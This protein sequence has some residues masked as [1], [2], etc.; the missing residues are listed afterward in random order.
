MGDGW[1]H[2]SMHD[3]FCIYPWIHAHFKTDGELKLCCVSGQEGLRDE[4]GVPL[5]LQHHSLREI[6]NS[7]AL[8]TVRRK[9]MEGRRVEACSGCYHEES[10]GKSSHR[11]WANEHWLS[12][13][14]S[15]EYVGRVERSFQADME[16]DDNP[17]YYD[18]RPG[19]QCNLACRMC[20]PASSSLIARDEVAKA[21]KPEETFEPGRLASGKPWYRDEAVLVDELLANIHQ[22][23]KFLFAGGEPLLNPVIKRVIDI[24]VE[25]K[26]APKILLQFSTNMT[27]FDEGF[28][29]KMRHFR[30]ANF[31]LSIDGLA[32]E[33]EY[34]RYP[35][36]WS[37]VEENLRKV[38]ELPHIQCMVTPT[39]QA[40]NTLGLADLL[41]WSDSMGFAAVTN[42][43]YNPKYLSARILPP[44]AK[45]ESARRLRDYVRRSKLKA[46]QPANADRVEATIKEFE[47]E[48]SPA[49]RQD[50]TRQ[51]NLYC[52]D[53]DSTRDQSFAA[54]HPELLAFFEDSGYRWTDEL[55]FA[56]VKAA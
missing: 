25:E 24:L 27:V 36:K 53:L 37:T 34:I 30:E 5:G 20:G 46:R 44:A 11:V 51:F 43:L 8:R 31:M 1:P 17:I 50:L 47:T 14:E 45:Q 6:W 10:L 22:T 2:A 54:S 7:P 12:Q 13:A 4:K 41:E 52:N 42:F 3:T 56:P 26:A 55:R 15:E 19:N 35:G 9:M 23:R 49:E 33:Y 40:L 29:E 16:V 48:P 32:G 28:F 39:V 38:R 18:I 21:W